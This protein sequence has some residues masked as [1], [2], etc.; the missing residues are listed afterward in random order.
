MA[1]YRFR[2]A[3][4]L[5]LLG[6]VVVT[7]VTSSVAPPARGQAIRRVS[8]DSNGVEGNGQSGSDFP[9]LSADGRH[10][11]F[12]S[13]T[14]DFVPND[15]NLQVDTFLVDRD[16]QSAGWTNYGAGFA[17]TN[18]VPGLSARADPVLGTKLTLDVENS[19]G[20]ATPATLFLGSSRASIPTAK[21]GTLLVDAFLFL[22]LALPP[23]DLPV[24]GSLPDDPTL[25]GLTIDLQVVEADP[26]AAFGLSFTAGL[27]LKLGY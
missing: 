1:P 9:A 21:G 12:C 23:V 13:E 6:P 10:V 20:A 16:A 8:I 5:A 24:S 27:E 4:R 3:A 2:R 17:G 19:R 15:N 14:T 7:L 11:A 26:G 18:G 25:V 22:P